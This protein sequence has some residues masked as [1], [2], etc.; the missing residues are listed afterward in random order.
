[1]VAHRHQQL[2]VG[3]LG[4]VRAGAAAAGEDAL[5]AV[6]HQAREAEVGV[7]DALGGVREDRGL[8]R[9]RAR[10]HHGDRRVALRIHESQRAQAVEPG[11]RRRLDDGVQTLVVDSRLEPPNLLGQVEPLGAAGL[12]D[13]VDP[14]G[15]LGAQCVAGTE[16]QVL[17]LVGVHVCRPR[18]RSRCRT[19]GSRRAAAPTRRRTGWCF[20]RARLS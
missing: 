2:A 20:P 1:M 11:V 14:R 7:E 6:A 8:G 3:R 17:Y 5:H 4:A 9:A 15:N 18:S 16:S 10:R 19:R 12:Q 13:G